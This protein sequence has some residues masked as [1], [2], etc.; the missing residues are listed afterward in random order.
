MVLFADQKIR[1]LHGPL[2]AGDAYE[3]ER[4][5][6]A[7]TGSRRTESIWLRTKVFAVDSGAPVATM[8]LNSALIKE[9]YAAY[10]KEYA[11]LYPS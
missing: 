9:S 8:L 5:V 10:L 7:V 2:F 3:I 1:L 6:V 4:E 11:E